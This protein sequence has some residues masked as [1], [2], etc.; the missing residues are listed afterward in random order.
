MDDLW[1]S[2]N[3]KAAH[4]SFQLA[5]FSSSSVSC[6]AI[7]PV[8]TGSIGDNPSLG[9]GVGLGSVSPIGRASGW[10]RQCTLQIERKSRQKERHEHRHFRKLVLIL[11]DI[12]IVRVVFFLDGF[13]SLY[14]DHS[15]ILAMMREPT[16]VAAAGLLPVSATDGLR[17]SSFVR[18][19]PS[20]HSG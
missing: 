16:C 14:L 4:S 9:S 19:P 20:F 3:W 11:E 10:L 7:A 13:G 18:T 17:M 2:Y 5:P 15:D 12:T 1:R 6:G 8:E